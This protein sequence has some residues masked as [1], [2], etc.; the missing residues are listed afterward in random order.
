MKNFNLS[1]ILVFCF[2]FFNIPIKADV[3][4]TLKALLDTK[5][6]SVD[7]ILIFN[8]TNNNWLKLGNLSQSTDYYKINLTSGAISNETAVPILKNGE[9]IYFTSENKSVCVNANLQNAQTLNVKLYSLDG[10]LI[11]HPTF[12]AVSGKNKFYLQLQNNGVFLVN[13]EG[14]YNHFSTKLFY[15]PDSGNQISTK[16]EVIAKRNISGNSGGFIYTE[17][18]RIQVLVKKGTVK[19]PIWYGKPANGTL[20]Q[21]AVPKYTQVFDMKQTLSKGA[22][23]NT[24]SFSGVGFI[25]GCFYASTFYPPG[26][27]SDYF[28]FQYMRDNDPDESGHNT[29]FLT[30]AA[31]HM[32]H[33]L[34]NQ[35]LQVL[36]DLAVAQDSLFTAYAINRMVL[37]KAF[38][39]YLDNDLPAGKTMLNIDSVKAVSRKLYLIDAEI[40]Y[41]RAVKFTQVINSLTEEQR[42]TLYRLGALGMQSWPMPSKPTVTIP[43]NMNTWVM[44]NASE[45]FS[46]FLRG[47]DADVYFCP[48]RQG[49]YFGGFYMKDAPA[50]GNPGYAI[51][52]E[53]T[54]NKGAYM[55]DNILTPSQSDDI[56]SIYTLVSPSLTNIVNCR[57][58]ISNELR[59]Q[60]SGET[61]NKTNILN[62]S[63][64]YGE[65]DGIYIYNMVDKFVKVA[66]TLTAD[67]KN[68]LIKL[69]DLA[70]Y[71]CIPGRVFIYSAE[72]DEPTLPNTDFLFK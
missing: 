62:W 30:K 5:A 10:K 13:I 26:K 11:L 19:S 61:I 35:Q 57:T 1:K 20:I 67:Q 40:S 42:D 8:E 25:S 15:S 37:I 7:S 52:M 49:T 41:G 28:G 24:I 45:L 38:H 59:K 44:S 48:E 31:Y 6:T 65:Y 34:N 43:R 29:D 60:I 12:N 55:L 70:D 51:D 53:A 23:I 21:L 63:A 9:Q 22:Q 69:R 17:G 3:I 58:L 46:W 4:V 56:K 71:P 18:N 72:T 47:V 54:A 32:M 36:I 64:Q 68:E 2:L 50:V 33:I 39:R 27:V 66:R 16:T 14:K